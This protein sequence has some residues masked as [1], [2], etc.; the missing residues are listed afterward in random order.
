MT[1][2][3]VTKHQLDEICRQLV[4][5]GRLMEAGFAGL[6][7][8]VMHRDAPPL[9]VK[10]MRMAFFAGAQHLFASIMGILEPGAEPTEND[11]ARL[12]LIQ[13]ELESYIAAYRKSHDV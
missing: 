5:Q 11:L 12:T 13:S 4:D 10:E 2:H 3:T 1:D 8:G 7:Y 9:Q 6:R